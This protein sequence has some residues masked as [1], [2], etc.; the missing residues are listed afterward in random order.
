MPLFEDLPLFDNSILLPNS[1]RGIICGKSGCGKTYRLFDLLLGQDA[2]K[3]DY[4]DYN[5][6][7][8]CTTSTQKCYEVLESC[9]NSR[10][11]KHIINHIF[12]NSAQVMKD[13][14]DVNDMIQEI[15]DNDSFVEGNISFQLINDVSQIPAPD[16]FS[17]EDKT[18]IVLDDCAYEKNQSNIEKLFF[19]GRHSNINVL[20]LTQS[21]YKIP[22][23]SIRDNSNLLLLFDVKGPDRQHLFTDWCS[24]DMDYRQFLRFYEHCCKP[25]FGFMTVSLD[26]DRN[27]G[28]YRNGLNK[29]YIN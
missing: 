26:H 19:K 15:V 14:G 6:L 2:C 18:L 4:L 3:K 1:F 5:N 23:Q 12:K 29:F 16:E 17:K 25:K 22:K 24:S 28:R 13:Y 7:V 8:I 10:L 20:Y 21:Y 27:V 9:F 11:P